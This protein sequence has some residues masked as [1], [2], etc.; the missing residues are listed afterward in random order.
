M[1]KTF[2]LLGF[3]LFAFVL[4]AQTLSVTVSIDMS[5]YTGKSYT[6]V[7]MNG[8]FK[9]WGNAIGLTTNN[10]S[11]V[12]TAVVAMNPGVNDYRFEIGGGE[13][14]WT[15]EW[16]VAG[17]ANSVGDCFVNPDGN[18]SNMR[19]VN[20]SEDIV[21]PT[22]NWES[23]QALTNSTEM[24]EEINHIYISPNP[25]SDFIQIS[26]LESEAN[27]SIFS[28]SGQQILNQNTMVDE[29]I[30]IKNITTGLYLVKIKSGNE[31]RV[32]K[33]IKN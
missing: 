15:A 19:W 17:G 30:N 33:L 24:V 3:I 9:G 16:E 8:G 20:I 27:V 4:K 1:K 10:D 23:C 11:V 13:I 5:T 2:L 28:L 26:K 25:A 6:N 32:F 31:E 14:G 22:V 21:L 7:M 18:Q 12:W 29:K